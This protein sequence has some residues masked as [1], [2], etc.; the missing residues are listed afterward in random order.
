[1]TKTKAN[2]VTKLGD[3][4]YDRSSVKH[5]YFQ[6]LRGLREWYIRQGSDFNASV[7]Y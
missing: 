4:V 2:N 5:H 7:T 3:S 1:M 6:E